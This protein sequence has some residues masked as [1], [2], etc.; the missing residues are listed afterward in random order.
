MKWTVLKSYTGWSQGAEPSGQHSPSSE[1]K[2]GRLGTWKNLQGP[3]ASFVRRA[4]RK[5]GLH[6]GTLQL[7]RKW[8]YSTS[9]V[10]TLR[11][12]SREGKLRVGVAWSRLRQG[13]AGPN[14]N[15]CLLPAQW[16]SSGIGPCQAEVSSR[17][18]EPSSTPL[19]AAAGPVAESFLGVSSQGQVALISFCDPF[20]LDAWD[21]CHAPPPSHGRLLDTVLLTWSPFV[22]LCFLS[23]SL[24]Y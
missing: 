4:Q 6:E 9:F 22:Y 13:K 10:S 15:P 21:L 18:Q 16:P 7:Q 1:T 24:C 8:N 12:S 23:I 14:V 5:L 2:W 11:L 19:L 3:G 17:H 20:P